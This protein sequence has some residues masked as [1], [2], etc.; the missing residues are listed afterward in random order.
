MTALLVSTTP[1]AAVRD[2][3]PRTRR[4]WAPE[5]VLL[6]LTGALWA[7]SLPGIAHAQESNF[8][9]LAAAPPTFAASLVLLVAAFVVALRRG[10]LPAMI[11]AV[12]AVIVLQR[13]TVT[14]TTP[15]PIYTWTYKHL[16]VVDYIQSTNSLA[17][18][19]D[20]YNEWPG[21]FAATAWFASVTGVDP[22]TLAHWFTPFI[23]VLFAIAMVA[24]AR[25]ARLTPAA[26][27]TAAF[28]VEQLNWVGQDYFSPQ[29]I[30]LLFAMVI[31]A[32]AL[33]SRTRRVCA[34]VAI[35]L[36]AALTVTHQ[37]TP[38]WLIGVVV[39]LSVTRRIRPWWLPI[40]FIAIAG[41]Y[42]YPRLGAVSSYGILQKFDPV[43]N[44]TTTNVATVGSPGRQLTGLS[45]RFLAASLWL[46]S[47]AA[48][49]Y[50]WR[51]RQPAV[52]G[53][54]LVVSAFSLLAMQSYG[55][56]AIFRVFLYALPGC[57]VLLAP[58]IERLVT[59]RRWTAS[60]VASVALV[61]SLA[62]MQG[63]VG[64]WF[65]NLVRP[66]E[67]NAARLL[68]ATIQPPANI[69][70]A[71]PIWPERPSGH[72]VDFARANARYDTPMVW[73]AGV[74]G[75]TFDNAA[76]VDKVTALMR[77][78]G[79]VPNYL[80]ISRQ[81]IEYCDYYGIFPRGSLDRLSQRLLD[82]PQWELVHRSQDVVVFRFIPGS[83]P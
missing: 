71:G 41:A 61:W 57:A 72:Y 78:R 8:G 30:A 68:L 4:R 49:L 21:L 69:T 10:S 25:C 64:G 76:D 56:E 80:V 15:L 5:W 7:V 2:E 14:L 16:G 46:T 75:S 34:W 35:P 60:L 66:T 70:M 13:L 29:A 62:S 26:A 77:G 22:V 73:A 79:N 58:V 11:T 45:V 24:L 47:I 12:F 38:Y 83:A 81:M 67:L 74:V 18:G 53:A 52:V 23:H 65:V 28:L 17:M 37:L 9:L 6:A 36:F 32:L 31:I 51:R 42:L 63:Y 82:N 3:L 1:D 39:L 20:V 44:A 19:V 54:L 40:V 59:T 50:L 33:A 48:A 43:G 27:W 55:G